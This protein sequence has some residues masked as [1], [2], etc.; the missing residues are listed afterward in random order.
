VPAEPVDVGPQDAAADA[1]AEAPAP[2]ASA[3]TSDAPADAGDRAA[4]ETAS[5]EASETTAEP[6]GA[7]A[8]APRVP[9]LIIAIERVGGPEAVRAALAP[10]L[11]E[12]GQPLKWAAVCCD[13][14]QGLKPGD[15]LFLAWIR[16]AGTPVRTIKQAWPTR[17]SGAGRAAATAGET[18][19][20][21]AA[22]TGDAAATV[23]A[24]A[25]AEIAAAAGGATIA[26]RARIGPSRQELAQH[27]KDGVLSTRVRIVTDDSDERRERER[28]RKEEREAKR[29]AER[30]RLQ[31]LGY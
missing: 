22:A 21:I 19:A 14:S 28:K 8:P 13:A 20:A 31:R 16:L 25:V 11:D 23:A 6:A 3:A 26:A 4:G 10:K 5:G 12:K 2:D 15:P 9:R 27:A 17:T 7:A 24:G 29:Q 30:E 1:P 18:A